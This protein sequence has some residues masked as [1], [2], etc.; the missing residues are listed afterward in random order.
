MDC[1]LITG[2][3]GFIA[4]RTAKLLLEQGYKTVGVD[5]LNDYYSVDLKKS[6]LAELKK[7]ENFDFYEIDIENYN[8]LENLFKKYKF[9]AAIN[10]AARAG[11]RYSIENPF[12]YLSTNAMGA[13]NIME[14]SARYG[15]KKQILASS[16]SLYAGMEPPFIESMPVDKPISQY[17]A[18]KKAAEVL[19]YSYRH[20]Y[21][22][23]FS[24]LRF[25]TVYGEGGRP[26]MSYFKFVS[27]IL[28]D[29]PIEIY[30]DGLQKRD[31]TY[32]G[33][34]ASGIVASLKPVGYEIINLGGGKKP[35]SIN[36]MISKIEEFCGKKATIEYKP[37]HNADMK[38]TGAD[39]SKAKALLGWEPIEKFESG[40]EKTV[41]W[42][43]NNPNF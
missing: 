28:K 2:A 9:S 22:L 10:L 35:V 34:I 1:I 37:F 13:L 42:H 29:K 12:V 33:D 23:D 36:Y 24:I 6:R 14:L 40:L 4:S 5:N 3:A 15:V 11:V 38:E 25:F 18:T 30:G 19:A 16:S 39:I 43:L 7:Y 41:K 8:D 20:L 17:A 32:V 31:F 26:D 27:A 21:D